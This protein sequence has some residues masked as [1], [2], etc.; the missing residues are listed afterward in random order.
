MSQRGRPGI[1]EEE[2][3][4]VRSH[5]IRILEEDYEGNKSALARDMGLSQPSIGKLVAGRSKVSVETIVALARLLHITEHELRTG[6]RG[7]FEDDPSFELDTCIDY[8]RDRWPQNVI[9][10]ARR[11]LAAGERYTPQGW[12]ERLDEL[13]G[14]K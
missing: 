4:R 8:W 14:R 12:R 7:R 2:S 3:E 11:K 1:P 13:A 9:A 5:L 6:K 10:E